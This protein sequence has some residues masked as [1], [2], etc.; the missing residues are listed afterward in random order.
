MDRAIGETN[1]RRSI[2][3]AYNATHGITPETVKKKIND[4]IGDIQR[5]RSRA[6]DQ[7]VEEDLIAH[8]GDVKKLIAEKRRQMHDAA[9]SLDFETAALLRDE[10]QRLESEVKQEKKSA[11]KKETQ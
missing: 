5:A 1:R 2:Q 8:G 3:M 4:I 9:D 6:V 11:K 10:I 7:L